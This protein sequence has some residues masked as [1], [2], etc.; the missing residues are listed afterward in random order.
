MTKVRVALV[1]L[2]HIVMEVVDM[3]SHCGGRRDAGM[4]AYRL[5]AQ[6]YVRATLLRAPVR[7]PAPRRDAL[8]YPQFVR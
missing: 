3:E 1:L 7:R 5:E 2:R 4:E 8:R 6:L